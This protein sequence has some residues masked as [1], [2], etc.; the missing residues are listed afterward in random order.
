MK[1]FA[2]FA[3]AAGLTAI[4]LA[5]G[6]ALL[7]WQAADRPAADLVT[8]SGS[9]MGTQWRI[10]LA[11]ELTTE[12]TQHLADEVGRNLADAD[13]HFSHWR[14]DSELSALN[15]APVDQWVEV[16]PP[17]AE[18]LRLGL[19]V[20][21]QTQGAFDFT[22]GGL[23]DLWG[24]GPSGDAGDRPPSQAA[25][26]EARQRSGWRKLHLDGSRAVRRDDFRLDLSAIAKGYTVDRIADLL[27][28]KGY[29]HHLVEIGGELRISGDKYGNPWVL[30]ISRPDALPGV[31]ELTILR[32]AP[33]DAR[34]QSPSWALA[35]SGDYFKYFQLNGQ[36]YAHLLD[37]R[38][39]WPS[40]VPATGAVTASISVAD[41]SCARADALATALFIMPPDEALAWAERHRVPVLLLLRPAASE[42]EA[43]AGEAGAREAARPKL[44]QRASSRWRE[45]FTA[46]AGTEQGL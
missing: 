15:K 26:D 46:R 36:R 18:V 33:P 30:G 4:V 28:Q 40:A 20:A 13:W 22:I 41:P 5:G 44:Q 45:L 21:G 19:E 24:F 39:G 10:T 7:W 34:T 37:P 3:P 6:V 12:Q 25:V 31:L 14:A 9:A 23:V 42:R 11:E 2:R 38:T 27:Q 1:V 17:L 43:G 35:T 29:W 32:R 8:L 16:S